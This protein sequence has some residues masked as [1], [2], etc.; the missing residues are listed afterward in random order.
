MVLISNTHQISIFDMS[1]NFDTQGWV[2]WF[3]YYWCWS[4]IPST[5]LYYTNPKSVN[6]YR[7]LISMHKKTTRLVDCIGHTTYRARGRNEALHSCSLC[8]NPT[9]LSIYLFV[10]MLVYVQNL[11]HTSLKDPK[12]SYIVEPTPTPSRLS[13]AFHPKTTFKFGEYQ[14]SMHQVAAY[15]LRSLDYIV[16]LAL[17]RTCQITD[18]QHTH[19]WWK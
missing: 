16:A 19:P 2:L 9:T 6:T 14:P 18:S 7:I 12:V 10:Y 3:H 4:L 13:G 15:W 1:Y 11:Q 8:H 17:K 5:C